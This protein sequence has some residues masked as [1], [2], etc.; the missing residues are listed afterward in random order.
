[1]SFRLYPRV[2]YRVER[3]WYLIFPFAGLV[4]EPFVARFEAGPRLSH[5]VNSGSRLSGALDLNPRLDM[6]VESGGR[7]ECKTTLSKRMQ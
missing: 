7:L 2:Q 1:M 4:T 6:E 5:A 3:L